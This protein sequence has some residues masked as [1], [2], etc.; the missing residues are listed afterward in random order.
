MTSL[1]CDSYDTAFSLF[2]SSART[3]TSFWIPLRGKYDWLALLGKFNRQIR[4]H[5]WS[6]HSSFTLVVKNFKEE[7]QILSFGKLTANI[8]GAS[9]KK[10]ENRIV[11]TLKKEKEGEWHTVNDKGAPDNEVV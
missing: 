7:D 4:P 8:T 1:L 9:C 3:R 10:Q 6:I 5:F 11:V 2:R